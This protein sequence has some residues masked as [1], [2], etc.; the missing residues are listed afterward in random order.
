MEVHKPT[1]VG[2]GPGV[3]MH[4][5][6]CAICHS[7]KA[8]Y[9]CNEG[10]FKPC[11]ICQETWETRRR[12]W[13]DRM[14]ERLFVRSKEASDGNGWEPMQ[15]DRELFHKGRRWLRVKNGMDGRGNREDWV[16]DHPCMT[17]SVHDYN[18]QE[19]CTLFKPIAKTMKGAMDK[20]F[21][22]G[23][24]KLKDYI[25]RLHSDLKQ[26]EDALTKLGL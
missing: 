4:D 23:V 1:I 3:V 16:L 26:A 24:E 19:K 5:Q 10:I 8:V 12:G 11:W 15:Y 20:A 14:Y 25:I 13:L 17:V 21:L 18:W 2:V 22:E 9:Q 7:R 6:A